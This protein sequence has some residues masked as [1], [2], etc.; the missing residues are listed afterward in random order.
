MWLTIL[1]AITAVSLLASLVALA[2]VARMQ[3]QENEALRREM[4]KLKKSPPAVYDGT[5]RATLKGQIAEQ[6]APMLPG[7]PFHPSDFRFLGAPID[8]I[9]YVGLTGAKE[10]LGDIQ[11]VVLGDIKLGSAR[12]SPHQRMIKK[13]VEEGRVRWETIHIGQDFS[14]KEGRR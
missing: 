11:E 12:L 4:A 8:F 14:I 1:L 7:F 3:S 6:V 9:A 10:G 2:V 13:A 5:A